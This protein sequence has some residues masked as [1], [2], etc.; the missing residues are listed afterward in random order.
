MIGVAALFGFIINLGIY[1]SLNL[2]VLLSIV[3]VLMGH[4]ASSR[5]YMKSH[6]I[7][8]LIAGTFVGISTQ[9]I[10]SPLYL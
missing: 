2:I 4:V 1:Y 6:T 5:L 10:L 8:E 9:L 3:V 7:I